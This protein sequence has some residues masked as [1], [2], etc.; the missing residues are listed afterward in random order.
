M[1][2]SADSTLLYENMQIFY[3]VIIL[4]CVSLLKQCNMFNSGDES[5]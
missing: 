3:I 2:N 5:K 4:I 1:N